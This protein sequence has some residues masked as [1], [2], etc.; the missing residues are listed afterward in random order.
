MLSV[1]YSWAFW[2]QLSRLVALGCLLRLQFT[3]FHSCHT[4]PKRKLCYRKDYRAMRLIYTARKTKVIWEEPPCCAS[5]RQSHWLQWKVSNFPPSK[6]DTPI[7]SPTP[8]A[9]PTASQST[10]P[11]RQ[12]AG[13][14]PTDTVRCGTLRCIAETSRKACRPLWCF[15]VHAMEVAHPAVEC[16]TY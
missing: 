15:T 2:P 16:I 12:D 13:C 10:Q 4:R 7:Q 6:T 1:Y 9:I 11:F 3:S 14:E 8:T 5:R